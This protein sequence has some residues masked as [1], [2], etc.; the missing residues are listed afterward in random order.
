MR[1]ITFAA[2]AGLV[3]LIAQ[4]PAPVHAQA[5]AGTGVVLMHGKTGSPG[6]NLSE[7]AAAL[8]KEGAVVVM[9]EM[10][11]SRSRIYNASYQ[12]A[13]REIEGAVT[14]LRK[15]GAKSVVIA[16]QSIGANAAIGYG[17]RHDDIAAVIAIAPGH[18]PQAESFRKKTGASVQEAKKLEAAGQGDKVQSFVDFN[19]G[20]VFDVRA[21]AKV[22]LS[23]L[24]PDGPAAMG[25]NAAAMKPVPFL[26]AIGR[27][28]QFFDRA[29]RVVYTPAAKNPKSRYVEVGG[30][31][32]AT[33]RLAAGAI[34][35][36]LK[37][38]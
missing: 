24:D 6:N 29:R 8:R 25:R 32:M 14:D 15:R 36:W 5:L 20:R 16:G 27:E 17:V 28:D 9:P 33:P 10:P 23:Y 30:G 18:N 37:S 19:Q 26:L 4:T 2:T 34:V 3:W 21:S 13:M 22:Y 38:L 12:D 11:W 35:D 7:L 1:K 31:H